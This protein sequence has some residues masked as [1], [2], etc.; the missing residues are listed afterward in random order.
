MSRR[1]HRRRIFCELTRALSTWRQTGATVMLVPSAARISFRPPRLRIELLVVAS[2]ERCRRARSYL[3]HAIGTARS[4]GLPEV[5]PRDRDGTLWSWNLGR[6]AR[7]WRRSRSR[8]WHCWV[9]DCFRN[10]KGL[11][12]GLMCAHHAGSPARSRSWGC[13]LSNFRYFHSKPCTSSKIPF[14]ERAGISRHVANNR[15]RRCLT[16]ADSP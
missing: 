14:G 9:W 11:R 15:R 16:R 1:Q 12:A 8:L 4:H 7:C 3:L 2:P 5:I 10:I 13:L 6:F